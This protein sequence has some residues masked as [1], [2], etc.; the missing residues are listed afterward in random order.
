MDLKFFKKQ[1][2]LFEAAILFYL[3]KDNIIRF[4]IKKKKVSIYILRAFQS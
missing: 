2:N 4:Y 1:L 3:N